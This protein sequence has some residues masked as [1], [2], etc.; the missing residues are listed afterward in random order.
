MYTQFK[1]PA[2]AL[3]HLLDVGEKSYRGSAHVWHT[4]KQ[5]RSPNRAAGA[6]SVTRKDLE[7]RIYNVS[8]CNDSV[9]IDFM[10]CIF[11]DTITGR[12]FPEN[13]RCVVVRFPSN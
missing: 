10:D 6:H 5:A 2:E 9:S 1:T 13:P 11:M 7:G 3:D 4:Y 12:S 8:W